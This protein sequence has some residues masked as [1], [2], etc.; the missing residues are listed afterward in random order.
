MLIYKSFKVMKT[1]YP[2]IC[3]VIT[4]IF[5]AFFSTQI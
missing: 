2:I 4:N 5:F 3:Y 1:A